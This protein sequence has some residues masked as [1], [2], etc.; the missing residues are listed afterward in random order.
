MHCV[1][2][3]CI[4]HKYFPDPEALV[5]PIKPLDAKIDNADPGKSVYRGCIFQRR[6]TAY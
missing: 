5:D 6:I 2:S 4:S 3:Y 1:T